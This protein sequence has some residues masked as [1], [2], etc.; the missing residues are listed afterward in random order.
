MK[1]LFSLF[2]L[3]D[4]SISHKILEPFPVALAKHTQTHPPPGAPPVPPLL[5]WFWQI[6]FF[7]LCP[8]EYSEAL[9]F[10]FSKTLSVTSIYP[11]MLKCLALINEAWDCYYALLQAQQLLWQ[12]VY[13]MVSGT[14][15][16][17]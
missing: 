15:E 2:H 9:P 5:L 12:I 10:W 6:E 3:I 13:S 17:P 8:W 7:A 16:T 14:V 11:E 4:F 1:V